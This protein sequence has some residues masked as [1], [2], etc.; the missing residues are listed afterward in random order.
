MVGIGGHLFTVMA[1]A[2]TCF[3]A[4]RSYALL[5]VPVD[6]SASGGLDKRMIRYDIH[7]L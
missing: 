4:L 5:C 2:V 3:S 6:I 1:L 7:V